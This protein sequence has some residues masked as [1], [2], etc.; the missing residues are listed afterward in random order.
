MHVAKVNG[1]RLSYGDTGEAA[2]V[3]VLLLVHG[4]PF[5][6]AMWLPQVDAFSAAGWRV[7][8]P[9]LRGYGDSEVKS[10]KVTLDAFAQDLAS[11]LDYV[12]VECVVI[13][14]LSMG[15]QIVMEF[16]RRYPNRVKGII[17]AATFPRSET[18]EGK[19]ERTRTADRLLREGMKD[20]ATEL[21]PKMLGHRALTQDKKIVDHVLDMMRQTDP[22]GAAAAL[23]GRAER[24]SYEETLARLRVPA[25][26]VVGEQDAYTTRRDAEGMNELIKGSRL[27]WMKDVGHMPN[28]E[29]SEEFNAETTLFLQ[30]LR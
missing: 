29:N 16:C 1:I 4:H 2:N 5:N 28:L 10:D 25:L 11:L 9:D 30:A 20:Y 3:S 19:H 6:R 22:R 8:T 18:E 12:G 13:G 7:L 15:G 26:I 21:L 23:R 24:P 14:G 27:V 17:L